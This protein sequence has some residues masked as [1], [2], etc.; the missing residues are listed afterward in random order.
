MLL[1]MRRNKRMTSHGVVARSL[2]A[3]LA[4]RL[5]VVAATSATAAA[6]PVT[7][8][9]QEC[10]ADGTCASTVPS[11]RGGGGESSTEKEERDDQAPPHDDPY[12]ALYLAESTIP[13]AGMGI[14]TF[15]EKRKG[16]TISRGDLCIPF[17]DMYWYVTV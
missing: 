13:G 11:P 9:E 17:I 7:V 3:V 16:E 6:D 2:V 14:F 8:E 1:R 10:T 12:C 5:I 4:L 15:E